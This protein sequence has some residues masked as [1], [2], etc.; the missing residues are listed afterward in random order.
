MFRRNGAVYP[1]S[2][3]LDLE[4]FIQFKLATLLRSIGVC[5]VFL[6]MI[7]ASLPLLA[8]NLQV[9]DIH[10]QVTDDSG[11]LLPDAVVKLTSPALLAPRT[12]TTDKGG[13]YRFEQLPLGTY[14]LEFVGTGFQSVARE[15]IV[16]TAG[17]SAEVNIQMGVGS[18]NLN[19]NVEASQGPVIDTTNPVLTTAIE[20]NVLSNELPVTRTMQEVVATTPGVMPGGVPDLGGGSVSG[21]AW[22]AYGLHGSNT[23]LIE[24]INTRQSTT[25]PG[26]NYDVESLQEFQVIAIGGGAEVGGPGVYIN[27]ILPY[28]G[29]QFHG[30][31]EARGQVSALQGNNLTPALQAQGLSNGTAS[32]IIH[33]FDSSGDVGGPIIKDKLWIFGEFHYQTISRT[34][35]G[36]TLPNGSAGVIYARETNQSIKA[37]YQLTPKYKLI[38]FWDMLTEYYPNRGG[39]AL[40]PEPSTLNETNSPKNWKAEIQ[41]LP[42]SRLVV[43]ANFGRHS[44]YLVYSAQPDPSGAPTTYDLSSQLNGGPGLGQDHR[45][46]SNWQAIGS[47]NYLPAGT[48]LGHHEL[49]F[50]TNSMFM[51]QGT[52]DPVG[53]GG[54]YALIF[55]NGAPAEIQTYNFPVSDTSTGLDEYGLY[56]TDSWKVSSRLSLS[57]GIRGD[58][59]KTYVPAQSKASGDFGPPWTTTAPFTGTAGAFPYIDSGSWFVAAPRIGLSWN[60]FGNGKTVLKSSYGRYNWSPGDDYSVAYNQNTSTNTTFKWNGP[61]PPKPAM[62]ALTPGTVDFDPNGPDYISTAGGSSGPGSTTALPNSV[63][64]PHLREQYTNEY[65][66]LMERQ[67]GQNISIRGG[68]S[69]AQERK[70]W[71]AEPYLIPYSAWDKPVQ[72]IDPGPNG[73]PGVTTT[74]TPLTIYDRDPAYKGAAFAQTQYF[75]SPN[76]NTY[77][78]LEVTGVGRPTGSRWNLLASYTATKNHRWIVPI[79]VNPNQNYFPVDNSWIWQARLTGNYNLKWRF[80]ISGTYQFYNGLQGQRTDTFLSKNVAIPV[81]GTIVVPV[82]PF[83]AQTGPVRSLLNLRLAKDFFSDSH[84]LRLYMEGLNLTNNASSWATNFNS[85]PSFGK[86]SQIDNPVIARFGGIF[87]F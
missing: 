81:A 2:S 51:T 49:K 22:T 68:Y 52:A 11:A 38:G 56:L 31:A 85:G 44:Y 82:E 46:R 43:D 42:N 70:V 4:N 20:A 64:N 53:L 15:N 28:G 69:L 35:L 59:F 19:V 41:G 80:D 65:Q 8:Q 13:Y 72:V 3:G 5:G 27:A 79:V 9:G 87:T 66:L 37:T 1:K 84:K 76:T 55:N 26:D 78:T 33:S 62:C 71:S 32:T 74:G 39:S 48:F 45:F 75:N 30:R 7:L 86:V 10:G 16:I 83:G 17:F 29:N 61:C 6:A 63:I 12:A 18:V 67:I 23:S 47:V 24:G 60:V 50:G 77:Q 25:A 21:G 36:Y 58:L 34:A 57:L 14:R 40:L 54:S 73:V